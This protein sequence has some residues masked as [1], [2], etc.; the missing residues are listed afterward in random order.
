MKAIDKYFKT[1]VICIMAYIAIALSISMFSKHITLPP[2]KSETQTGREDVAVYVS[3]Y[4]K[5]AKTYHSDESCK[6]LIGMAECLSES[7]AVKK[8]YK[9]CAACINNNE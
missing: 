7:D 4:N 6:F 2:V 1:I 3:Q 8:G 9:P 5:S